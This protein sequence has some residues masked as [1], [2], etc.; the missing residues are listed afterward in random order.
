MADPSPAES[1]ESRIPNP[2]SRIPNPES[3]T[4]AVNAAPLRLLD[5]PHRQPADGVPFPRAR[6]APAHAQSTEAEEH[7]R[8]DEVVRGRPP[9]GLARGVAGRETGANGRAGTSR[10]RVE[11][12]RPA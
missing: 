10:P 9:L 5:H 7:G 2:E 12:G 3:R 6:G 1:P 11:T 8:G 4:I